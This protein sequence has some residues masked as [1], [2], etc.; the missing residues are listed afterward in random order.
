MISPWAMAMR[1]FRFVVI[2]AASLALLTAAD[3]QDSS[4][5]SKRAA[6]VQT[7]EQKKK[8][9]KAENARDATL[10]QMPYQTFDP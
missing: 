1:A 9:V 7:T 10:K 6:D 2:A 3:A 5:G 8:A 4:K